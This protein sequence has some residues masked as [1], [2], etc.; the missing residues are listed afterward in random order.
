MTGS[1]INLFPIPIYQSLLNLSF[2]K[3]QIKYISK[4]YTEKN[5]L[6]LKIFKNIKQQLEQ[7]SRHCLTETLCVNEKVKIK[8][9]NSF[10]DFC[11]NGKSKINKFYNS[12]LTGVYC[13]QAFNEDE[14]LFHKNEYKQIKILPTLQTMYN[15][16]S[17][18]FPM[19]HGELYLFPSWLSFDFSKR[20][21]QIDDRIILY[22]NTYIENIGKKEFTH[23]M[24]NLDDK[25]QLMLS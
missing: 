16:Y 11:L 14:I 8:I 3:D 7:S 18:K 22:F 24:T 20:K 21:N 19:C 6:N 9:S 23:W 10:F 4:K 17:W 5:P 13:F 1:I 25:K 15:S 12:Y 2:S